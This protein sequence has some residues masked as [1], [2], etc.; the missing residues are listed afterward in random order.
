MVISTFNHPVSPTNKNFKAVL[1]PL[2]N[3]CTA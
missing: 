1:H 2:Y 3:Q